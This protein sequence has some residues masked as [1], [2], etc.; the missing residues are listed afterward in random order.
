[1]EASKLMKSILIFVVFLLSIAVNIEDNVVARLGFEANYLMMA[2]IAVV[3]AGLLTYKRVMLIVLVISLS[4]A[5]NMPEDFM[6]NFGVDRD[7]L[8]GVLVAIVIVPSIAG[9]LDL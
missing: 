2:L 8:L 9:I 4:V 1:M 3:V 5:A 6:L 7:L